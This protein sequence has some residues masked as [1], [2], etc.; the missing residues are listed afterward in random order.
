MAV[1]NYAGR[2]NLARKHVTCSAFEY[3]ALSMVS[4]YA[5]LG[6]ND[7]NSEAEVTHATSPV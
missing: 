1:V 7:G 2:S 3:H 5:F 6:R 4:V